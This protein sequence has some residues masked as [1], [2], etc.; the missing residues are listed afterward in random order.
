MPPVA[1][2]AQIIW[3]TED[4]FFTKADQLD[5]IGALTSPAVLFQ[6]KAGYGHDTHWQGRMGEEIAADVHAF[7][8]L[9]AGQ[10]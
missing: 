7:L 8:G 10:R 3:G 9:L 1:A 5:L 6:T 4:K 2:P